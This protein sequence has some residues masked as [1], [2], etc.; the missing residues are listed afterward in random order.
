MSEAAVAQAPKKGAKL[1]LVALLGVLLAAGVG[2][3]T[4]FA[5][6][7]HGEGGDEE[8][9]KPRAHAKKA[10]K[11]PLFTTLEPFTVNL[12]DPRGERF[13]QI[14]VTLQFED[15]SVESDLKDHLPAVRN[16]ILMLISSKQIED[17]LSVEGKVKLAEEIRY[18]AGKSMGV[19]LPEP[20]Q[21]P[22][23]N[24]PENPL[25]QVLFSQFILQ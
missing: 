11:K 14:G 18:R 13:A 2:G 24:D 15:A 8:P 4:W 23:K 1:V 6:R 10:D 25:T 22:G 3:G 12:Q 9:S 20:G 7:G 19:D 5:M 21:K 16:S 17:L